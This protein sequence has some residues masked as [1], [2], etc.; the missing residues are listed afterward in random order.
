M[1]ISKEGRTV[2]DE[3]PHVAACAIA[4]LFATYLH[5]FLCVL[6]GKIRYG[7][8]KLDIVICG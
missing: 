1:M 4:S 6:M 8:S 2:N 7:T 5:P 3:T